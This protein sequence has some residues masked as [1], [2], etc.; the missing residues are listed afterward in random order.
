M[1]QTFKSE[2][3]TLFERV[4]HGLPER[5]SIVGMHDF[6]YESTAMDR[7]LFA[8]ASEDLIHAVIFPALDVFHGVPDKD[9]QLRD[10]GSDLQ[11]PRAL[12]KPPPPHPRLCHG[13]K[14]IVNSS[15]SSVLLHGNQGITEI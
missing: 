11:P 9:P 1:H 2:R 12:A 8:R 3:L 13:E 6:A 5:I 15:D 14:S 4:F 7:P 10:L